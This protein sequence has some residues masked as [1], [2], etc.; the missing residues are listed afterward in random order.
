MRYGSAMPIRPSVRPASGVEPNLAVHC[1]MPVNSRHPASI[2]ATG[3]PTIT[4]LVGVIG[5]TLFPDRHQPVAFRLVA[6]DPL[7]SID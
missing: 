7:G 3:A 5:E 1:S 4:S 2:S 6:A